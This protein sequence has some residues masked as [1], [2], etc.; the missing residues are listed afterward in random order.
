MSKLSVNCY[1]ETWISWILAISLPI[2]EIPCNDSSSLRLLSRCLLINGEDVHSPLQPYSHCRIDLPQR[3]KR[4]RAW[5]YVI[6]TVAWPWWARTTLPP[7]PPPRLQPS[8]PPFLQPSYS[9]RENLQLFHS[10]NFQ[11]R[12]SVL[13]V[14]NPWFR[15]WVERVTSGPFFSSSSAVP[16]SSV[17]AAPVKTLTSNAKVPFS[18]VPSVRRLWPNYP[19]TTILVSIENHLCPFL[20]SLVKRVSE[21]DCEAKKIIVGNNLELQLIYG[22]S[23]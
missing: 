17:T 6:Q 7:T 5:L 15:N 3:S 12:P 2:P 19:E 23:I 8:Q 21:R 13:T 4:S 16:V 11:T 22:E 9:G 14:P 1:L 10:R 20:T 18:C